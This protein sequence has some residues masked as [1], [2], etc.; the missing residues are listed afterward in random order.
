MISR[1][2]APKSES[3]VAFERAHE[4]D[5]EDEEV[6]V[7]IATL[8]SELGPEPDARA[9][10]EALAK[11]SGVD[12]DSRRE[13]LAAADMPIDARTLV[14]NGFLRARN[15]VR[16]GLED[17]IDRSQRKRAPKAAARRDE[18]ERSECS[19]QQEELRGSVDQDQVPPEF[20][21]LTPWAVRLGVGD[22]VCRS[23]LVEGLAPDERSGLLSLTARHGTVIYA[24]LD[25]F[26]DDP[27]TPEAAA[28]MY[29]LLGVE[30][31]GTFLRGAHDAE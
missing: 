29:L 7:F 8:R 14:R 6:A 26:G 5:P 20:R 30:E 13:E 22:D 19:E 4:A 28:F 1:R 25:T 12:L 31:G 23:S 27:M 17:T 9:A 2:S 16:S 15:F 10:V 11:R 3:M 21:D 24:W 18:A